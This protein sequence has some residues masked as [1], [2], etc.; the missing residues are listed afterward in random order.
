MKIPHTYAQSITHG[1]CARAFRSICCNVFLVL[2]SSYGNC[3]INFNILPHVLFYVFFY[4][5]KILQRNVMLFRCID[6][7][8][9][10]LLL[11]SIAQNFFLVLLNSNQWIF[12]RCPRIYVFFFS[13]YSSFLF[14]YIWVLLCCIFY[15]FAIYTFTHRC[16]LH[17]KEKVSA[18]L[19]HSWNPVWPFWILN[20]YAFRK[21][22]P[23]LCEF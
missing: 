21:L 9:R 10:C 7:T 17:T 16:H 14:S 4:S 19:M 22:Y 20:L 6:W 23:F 1:S 8:A 13:R 3:N 15:N 11:F 2:E 5:F 18:D 12:N